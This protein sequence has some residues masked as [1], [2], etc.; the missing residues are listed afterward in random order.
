MADEMKLPRT[1]LFESWLVEGLNS[2]LQE[3]HIGF[4]FPLHDLEEQREYEPEQSS[5][6]RVE[7]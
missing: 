6:L 2:L 3:S 5:W 1:S 7:C 4:L